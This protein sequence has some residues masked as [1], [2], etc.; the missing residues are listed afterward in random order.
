MRFCNTAGLACNLNYDKFMWP[1]LE[2]EQKSKVAMNF[3][4]HH[5]ICRLDLRTV[6]SA[7]QPLHSYSNSFCR[8]CECTR[9]LAL[10]LLKGACTFLIHI[11]SF[12]VCKKST[13]TNEYCI[14]KVSKKSMSTFEKVQSHQT[15]QGTCRVQVFIYIWYFMCYIQ[16]QI[17]VY[18]LKTKPNSNYT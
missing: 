16:N 18:T 7:A 13:Q 14:K 8:S 5:I 9:L 17:N 2:F 6:Y 11:C 12:A 10:H 3:E 15:G 4:L 1:Q